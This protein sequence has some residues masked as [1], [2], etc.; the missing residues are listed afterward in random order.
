MTAVSIIGGHAVAPPA[1]PPGEPCVL[2]VFGASGDLTKRLL[3]PA[4]Y[5]LACEGLLPVRFAIAGI[6]ADDLSTEVVRDRLS[7]DIRSFHTR[8]AFD[9]AAWNRLCSQI[10]F[11]QG[12][13]DDPAAFDRLKALLD[14][15]AADYQT[16]G[17]T[18]FYL[19]VPPAL[20]GPVAGH[21]DRAG[22]R[23]SPGWKRLVVEKPFGTDLSSARAL[24]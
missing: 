8:N 5:N 18:I 23:G 13:F 7:Q 1:S 6:S 22:L 9:A 21:L 14:R 16:S 20:F 12:R 24:N 2:V 3:V 10:H 17:N 19:A 15:L 11:V 4:L